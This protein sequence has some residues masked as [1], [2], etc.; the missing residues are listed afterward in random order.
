MDFSNGPSNAGPLGLLFKLLGATNPIGDQDKLIINLSSCTLTDEQRAVLLKGLSFVPEPRNIK[1]QKIE[2]LRGL[3]A[4]HRRIKLET[5]FEGKKKLKEKLPFTHG[6]EWSPAWSKLPPQVRSLVRA[7][8]YAYQHLNWGLLGKQNLSDRERRA[9]KE[10]Q[11]NDKLIIKPADKGNAIVLMDID[12]Y[13]WEGNRQLNVKDHYRPLAEP[14]YP[15]TML[16]IREILEEMCEKKIISGKQKDYLLGSGTPRPRRFY[17]LPKIHKDPVTWSSPY[18][19]PPGRPIVSD[20][21]SESYY[22]AEY[23]E[24][25]LGPISQRHSSY[26]KDTYDFIEKTKDLRIP[27]DAFLFTIDIDSLYTNIETR[28][29]MLAVRECMK[30]F[31]DRKRPD[32]YILK[33]LEINLTKNDFEFNSEFHLQ[34]K[35]TAMGKK[36]APSYANIFMAAWEDS[37]LSSSP[38]KPSAYFRFLD[39]IWGVWT[40]SRE[41]FI[42]FTNHLNR[43]QKSIKIKF[44]IDPHQVN[45]LDVVTYKGP[46]FEKQGLLD[47][48]VYFKPTDTHCLLHKA[49]FHPKHTFRG[50]LKSQLLRFHRICSQESEFQ[51]AVKV[52]FKAL[53]K[54]GY[55]RTFLRTVLKTFK[56]SVTDQTEITQPKN[57]IIP[58]VTYYSVQSV[59]LNGATK[60]NFTKFL[61]PT[62]SLQ[63]HR[64]I[65]AYKRNK[66]L[67]DTLVC[68]KIRA[69]L[70]QTRAGAHKHYF[71]RRWVQ[72][73]TTKQIYD[74]QRN[75]SFQMSNCVYL[76]FCSKCHKQYVGQTK[77]RLLLRVYQHLYNIRNKIEARRFL[78]KHFL[79]HGLS[80][81]K[82]T[83][84][85][86]N[87]FWTLRERLKTEREWIK[88]LDTLYPR[89]LN[90]A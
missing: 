17:L 76:I 83:G 31:P 85:Q 39:D 71:L 3:Q 88:R 12:D 67:L 47:Y 58:L 69:P 61:E 5:Y 64:P 59:Q 11:S 60:E 16:E 4:Y 7:D 21:D 6:S 41:N 51:S 57:K 23:I 78:V 24:H 79:E 43:H 75:L 14:I 68:S 55:S 44:E 48:K 90:E 2:L 65:A 15:Q 32:E 72:N 62:H 33:L 35:G 26:L 70:P 77:N 37:A 30:K 84:L 9:V 27:T 34:I 25:F 81:L 56:Q 89:G 8:W 53:K 46:K 18:K 54:R 63:Q 28:A 66:N 73:K 45:F 20:C 42:A 19:I 87:P 10:L 38:L 74:V 52:L 1:T 13:I 40:Y 86:S 80:A 36:F 49:S 82:V 29:G 50:I 22:T